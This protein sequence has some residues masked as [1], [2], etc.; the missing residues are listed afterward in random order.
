M[1]CQVCALP[2]GVSETIVA[3]HRCKYRVHEYKGDVRPLNRE[4]KGP[5][6]CDYRKKPGKATGL[7]FSRSTEPGSVGTEPPETRSIGSECHVTSLTA[8]SCKGHG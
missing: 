7:P 6:I 3:L 1:E 4:K 5:E 2:F 8:P